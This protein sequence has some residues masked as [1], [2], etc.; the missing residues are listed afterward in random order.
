MTHTKYRVNISFEAQN[1]PSDHE[2]RRGTHTETTTC[3]TIDEAIEF[4]KKHVN[5]ENLV[6]S[7][8]NMYIDR[9]TEEGVTESVNIGKVYSYWKQYYNPQ[10][11]KR[12]VWETAWVK[13]QEMEIDE[14]PLEEAVE[15]VQSQ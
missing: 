5:I 1:S 13:I 11:G 12:N 10:S 7:G 15:Q 8:Q 2:S 3:D 6:E 14:V 9:E 4:V